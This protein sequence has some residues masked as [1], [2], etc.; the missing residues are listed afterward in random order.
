MST[1]G[2]LLAAVNRNKEPNNKAMGPNDQ[3]TQL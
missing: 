3:E 2:K 1:F